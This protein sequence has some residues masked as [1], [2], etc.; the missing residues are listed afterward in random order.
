MTEFTKI[1]LAGVPEQVNLPIT[2]CI[3]QDI[4]KKWGL[5]VEFVLVPEGTGAMITKLENG[6]VDLALTVSDALIVGIAS[7][8]RVQ[9]VGTFVDSP[10]VWAVAGNITSPYHSLAELMTKESLK[11]GVSRIGSGSHTMAQY[12]C[13]LHGKSLDT[14]SFVIANNLDGLKKGVQNELFDAFLWETFTTKPLFDAGELLKHGEVPTPWTAFSIAAGPSGSLSIDKE[15]SIRDKLFPALEEGCRRFCN[16]EPSLSSSSV[17]RIVQDFGHKE[18]DALA[19]LSKVKYNVVIDKDVNQESSTCYSPQSPM[20]I[21]EARTQE[22]VRILKSIAL[23]PD[24]FK[25]EDL[26][27]GTSVHR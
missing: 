1:V 11:F 14:V 27:R 13:A 5:E 26:W 15:T 7:G 2:Y 10:L 9:L 18:A 25:T 17:A 4:F 24:D 12:A 21:D 6:E 8:R 3:E 16:A 22:S 19:W 23:I 20:R